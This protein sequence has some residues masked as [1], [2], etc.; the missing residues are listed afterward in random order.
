MCPSPLSS[1][2]F[3]S[4]PVRC[5]LAGWL[6]VGPSGAAPDAA[7]YPS[8]FVD[9]RGPSYVHTS[10][11]PGNRPCRRPFPRPPGARLAGGPLFDFDLAESC[12]VLYSKQMMGDGVLTRYST[13][14]VQGRT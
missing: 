7:K 9:R 1:L 11:Y 8:T 13:P 2:R 12:T 3:S 14:R 6:A 10:S 5:F 4:P